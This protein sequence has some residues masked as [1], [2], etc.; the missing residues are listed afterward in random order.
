MYLVSGISGAKA[1]DMAAVAPVLFPE[2]RRRGSD[3]RELVALLNA[4]CRDVGDDPAK[5]RTDRDR[6][7]VQCFDRGAVHRRPGPCR[8]RGARPLGIGL[9][10]IPPHPRCRRGSHDD[11][12]QAGELR[13]R[14]AGA[15]A[16]PHHPDRGR[17]GCR[18]GH[19]G[20]GDRHRICLGLRCIPLPRA[21]VPDAASGAAPDGDPL[22]GHYP[23][24]RHGERGVLVTVSGGHRPPSRGQPGR[25]CR[26]E[27]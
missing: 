23:G 22:R 3:P 15:G 2:M 21:P 20:V 27:A 14:L 19:R 5:P 17:G 13:R 9:R 8:H 26:A 12:R 1:A 10:A 18:H 11:T 16:A 25:G 24:D 6:H 7:G 4:S